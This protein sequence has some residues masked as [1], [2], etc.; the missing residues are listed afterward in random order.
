LTDKLGKRRQHVPNDQPTLDRL[1]WAFE[2]RNG[3]LNLSLDTEG[4]NTAL[5]PQMVSP[6]ELNFRGEPHNR[7]ASPHPT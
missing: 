6:M 7:M 5:S 2:V 4:H 3:T 1:I